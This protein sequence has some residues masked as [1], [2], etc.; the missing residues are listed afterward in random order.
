LSEV[1]AVGNLQ[2]YVNAPQAISTIGFERLASAIHFVASAIQSDQHHFRC[3]DNGR[4]FEQKQP[5]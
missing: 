4:G 5:R 3:E 2:D 1:T